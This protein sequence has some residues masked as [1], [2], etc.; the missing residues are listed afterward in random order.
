MIA[1]W[2]G[3]FFFI[4]A[5]V[6]VFSLTLGKSAALADREF[7]RALV[8]EQRSRSHTPEWIESSNDLLVGQTQ[9]QRLVSDTR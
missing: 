5:I 6:L 2:I 3:T 1:I 7:E 8:V 9:S 4:Q